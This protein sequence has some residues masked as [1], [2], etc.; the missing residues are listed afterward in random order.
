MGKVYEWKMVPV[1]EMRAA[2]ADGWEYVSGPVVVEM[3]TALVGSPP[4]E[5]KARATTAACLMRR[6]VVG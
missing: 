3:D 1:P 4:T 2:S 5:M 6:E